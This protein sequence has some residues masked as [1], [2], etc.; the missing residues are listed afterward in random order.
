MSRNLREL[1]NGLTKLNFADNFQ[2][3]QAE[4][5]IAATS[6]LAVRNELNAVPSGKIIVKADNNAVVDG[7]TDNDENFVYLKN[8]SGTSAKVTVIWFK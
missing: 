1:F 2:S 8:P 5:T 6:E 3:F 7:D 4:V